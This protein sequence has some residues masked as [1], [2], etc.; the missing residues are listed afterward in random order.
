MT[1]RRDLCTAL[2]A[3]GLLA[4]ACDDDGGGN[5]NNVN[6]TAGPGTP[7]AMIHAPLTGFTEEPC[8]LDGSASLDPDGDP[9]SYTW[10]LVE[11]PEG[12][13]T[14]ISDAAASAPTLTPDLPG[15]YRVT[16][17]VSDGSLTSPAYAFTLTAFERGGILHVDAAATPGGD[18]TEAAPFDT[19]QAAVDHAGVGDA[20]LV[21]EGTYAG[22]V[23]LPDTAGMRLLGGY[24]PG[25]YGSR[26]PGTYITALEGD[27][28]MAV[29]SMDFGG[30]YGEDRLVMIDGFTI[31]GGLRGLRLEDQGNGGTL[32]ATISDNTIEDNGGLATA[33][34]YGGGILLSGAVATVSDNTVRNNDCGKGGGIAVFLQDPDYG[35][36]LTG[37]LVEGNS[38]HADHGGGVYLAAYRGTVGFNVIRDNHILETYGWAGGLI[39]DG[40]IWD[41]YTD[42][43]YVEL[44]FNVYEGN[45]APSSG[46]GLF[47]DEGANVRMR[48]EL[49]FDNVTSEGYSAGAVYVDGDRGTLRAVTVME[50]CTVAHNTGGEGSVGRGLFVQGGVEVHVRNSIIWGNA[51]DSS[52]LFVEE[53]C[54]LELSYTLHGGVVEGDGTFAEEVSLVTDPLF[55]DPGSGDFHLRSTAGRYDQGT[56]VTDTVHSPAI[57]AGDPESPFS[58][59][60]TPNGGRANLGTHGDTA[61]ASRGR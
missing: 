27:G 7:R 58:R 8:T 25:D 47:I 13:S 33:G 54:T 41:G 37:N 9:L 16:L 17:T 49:L 11:A 3:L 39:V 45:S 61:E 42:V 12:S 50:Q 52:D 4:F 59:E 19:I 24:A 1:C 31:T 56:W 30:Q 51:L 36:I 18:G 5:A 35:P 2:M 46:S 32:F 6:N 22:N 57:D 43:I 38:G 23:V 60:T 48:H 20:I 10:T 29:L 28:T 40:G 21:T 53:G 15:A 34:D 44:F 55:A 14:T 26:D